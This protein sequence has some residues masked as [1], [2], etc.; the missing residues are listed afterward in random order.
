M[1]ALFCDDKQ[2]SRTF[3]AE[4]E[5]WQYARRSSLVANRRLQGSLRDTRAGCC[6]Y[7]SESCRTMRNDGCQP[8]ANRS[9]VSAQAERPSLA[10]VAL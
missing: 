3:E 4:S 7:F 8:L 2:I 1:W 6:R 9:A 10:D 5:V